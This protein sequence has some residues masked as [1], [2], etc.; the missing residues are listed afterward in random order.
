VAVVGG[1]LAGC[2]S[3]HGSLALTAAAPRN[4]A[5]A[6]PGDQQFCATVTRQ[7][8]ALPSQP[9]GD[10]AGDASA[11]GANFAE[12]VTIAPP[13]IRPDLQVLADAFQG[14]G[15][16]GGTPPM[17]ALQHYADYLGKHCGITVPL[18]NMTGS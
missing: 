2:G 1:G 15:S 12:L 10:S 18:G 17:T 3:V 8:G 7:M 6:S 14:N 5:S 16:E 13:E 11:L 9:T 4:V